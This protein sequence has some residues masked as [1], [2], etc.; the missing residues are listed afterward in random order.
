MGNIRELCSR[1]SALHAYELDSQLK[2][3]TF[4]HSD[5]EGRS[6]LPPFNGDMTSRSA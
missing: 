1:G 6:L 2:V 5:D 3:A 4:T